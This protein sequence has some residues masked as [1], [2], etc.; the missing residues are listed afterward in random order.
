MKKSFLLVIVALFV[1]SR[2]SAQEFRPPMDHEITFAGNYA[3]IRAD[4]FHGG[5]DFKTGGVEG[6]VVRA[7]ADGYISRAQVNS[8]SGLSLTIKYGNGYAAAYRHLSVFAEPIATRVK[9]LQYEQKSWEMDL[10]FAPDEYVVKAGQEIARSGN[11]GYSMG[12]HLHLDVFNADGEYIDPLPFF[13]DKVKDNVAPRIEGFMIFPQ[14]GRGVVDGSQKNKLLPV[15]SQKNV[16]VWGWIGVGIRAYDY[17]DGVSNRYGVKVVTLSVDGK[18]VFNSKMD[19]FSYEEN[20]YINSWTEGEYM[21]CFIEPGNKLRLLHDLNGQRGLINID[22]ERPYKLD[23]TLID[24]FGNTTRANLVLQG[25]KQHIEPLPYTEEETLHWDRPN[26]WQRPGFDL[27]VPQGALYSDVYIDYQMSITD[28]S[29]VAPLYRLTDKAVKL[30]TGAE[31]RIGIRN[32]PVDDLTKYYVARV[33]NN[34]RKSSVGGTLENGFMK[35]K[36][37]QLGTFTVEV[38]TISPT[39][40]AINQNAWARNGRVTLKAEDSQTGISHYEAFIDGEWALLGKPNSVNNYLVLVL[41]SAH[42]KKG[43]NHL[44]SVIVTDGCGNQRME[45]FQFFW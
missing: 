25:R 26:V 44:L 38:D 41:D 8:S 35:V 22:E 16:N 5:L 20:R 2:L 28:S 40:E 32:M 10:Q 21:K 13:M 6:K 36:V 29:S 14:T 45:E 1:L 37:L 19:V 39:I 31:L 11:T 23:Y 12:P 30:H 15:S 9:T 24:A 7:L 4:H 27:F 18:E 33:G 42:V 34:G 43:Q 3:E 17:M